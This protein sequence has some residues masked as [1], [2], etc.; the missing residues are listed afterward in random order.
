MSDYVNEGISCSVENCKYNNKNYCC[1]LSDITV[2]TTN[3]NAN[4]KSDTECSSFE[5][6]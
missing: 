6:E 3:S 5:K 2:G 4:H 1:T